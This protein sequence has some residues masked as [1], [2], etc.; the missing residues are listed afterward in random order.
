MNLT[1]L[2]FYFRNVVVHQ[3][4]K[5]ILCNNLSAF[6][7]MDFFTLFILSNFANFLT[8]FV[9]F[10]NVSFISFFNIYYIIV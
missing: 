1:G 8:N 4:L 6:L 7:A 5:D 2:I 10:Y 9:R 3:I